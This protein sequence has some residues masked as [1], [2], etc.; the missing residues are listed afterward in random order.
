MEVPKKSFNFKKFFFILLLIISI[1]LLISC[2]AYKV[3]AAE[4]PVAVDSSIDVSNVVK[5]DS[6]QYGVI[7]SLL[8]LTSAGCIINGVILLTRKG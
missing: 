3:N 7:V 8:T 6:V 5:L 2:I 1:F 4:Q